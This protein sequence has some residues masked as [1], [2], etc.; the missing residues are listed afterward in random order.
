MMSSSS[1]SDRSQ[2]FSASTDPVVVGLGRLL[3]GVGALVAL[4]VAMTVA[5]LF[6]GGF[7]GI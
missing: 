7:G 5:W 3:I 6:L 2:L 1:G 4:G